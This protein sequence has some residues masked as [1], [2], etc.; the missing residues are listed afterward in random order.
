MDMNCREPDCIV[1]RHWVT[2]I[3]ENAF[4]K[5][6]HNRGG[7]KYDQRQNCLYI[8]VHV[9]KPNRVRLDHLNIAVR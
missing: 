5:G 2:T 8:L 3:E 7:H 4:L 9:S 6:S 1:L